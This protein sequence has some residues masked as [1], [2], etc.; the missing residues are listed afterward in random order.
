[1]GMPVKGL[2]RVTSRC[3]GLLLLLL[4]E[5]AFANLLINRVLVGAETT[6]QVSARPPGGPLEFIHSV[7]DAVAPSA[8]AAVELPVFTSPA[9]APGDTLFQPARVHA[10]QSESGFNATAVKGAFADGLER[11][12]L[13]ARTRWSIEIEVEL[14]LPLPLPESGIGPSGTF[15]TLDYLLFPGEIGLSAFGGYKGNAGI[16]A[17]IAAEDGNSIV[18]EMSLSRPAGSL[19]PVLSTSG[20]F[21]FS[22]PTM[23]AEVRDGLLYHV[24]KSG[25]IFGSANMG[26]YLDGE[27]FELSYDLEAWLEIPG[28]EVGGFARISDPFE[29]ANNPDAFIESQFPGLGDFNFSV[30]E[31]PAPVPVPGAGLMLTSG[32]LVLGAKCRRGVSSPG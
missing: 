21:A 31:T 29:L 15:V 7:P 24:A 13:V 1:M 26:R 20:D 22:P 19:L 23:G 16:R 28:F 12:F 27:V 32:L 30:R 9:G 6:I 8:E 25:P 18:S 2:K 3:G 4:A 5:P 14:D 10:F 17:R 11:H